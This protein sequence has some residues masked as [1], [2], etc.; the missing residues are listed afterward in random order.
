MAGA[1]AGPR[2]AEV[3]AGRESAAA[4]VPSAPCS[5]LELGKPA[6]VWPLVGGAAGAAV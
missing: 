4:A 1:G 6:A 5:G 3:R 2:G